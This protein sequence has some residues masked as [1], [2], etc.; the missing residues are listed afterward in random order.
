MAQTW[1]RKTGIFKQGR[2]EVVYTFQFFKR[3]ILNE[4]A[5]DHPAVQIQQMGLYL[6]RKCF[7]FTE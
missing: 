4:E 2:G 6:T 7:I 1:S 5:N 3:D